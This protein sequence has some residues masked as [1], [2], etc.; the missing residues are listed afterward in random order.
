M[1]SNKRY[2]VTVLSSQMIIIP[3]VLTFMVVFVP[4][5]NRML[6]SLGFGNDAINFIAW[7]ISLIES[8]LVGGIVG[9]VYSWRAKHKPDSLRERYMPFFFSI[10]YALIWAILVM[11]FSKGDYNSGWW[12][13]YMIK[14][15][16]LI[17]Y[18]FTQIF[19][20]NHY[21][22]PVA[23]LMG[24]TGFVVG[25]LLQEYAT[26]TIILG[27]SFKGRNLEVGF[28][29][30]CVGVIIVSG[31]TAKNQ[32]RDG[33]I[34]LR[35]GK[36]TLGDDLTEIDLVRIAP[37]KE[38]NG[39][40]K[41][42]RPASLQFT[43]LDKMPLLDGATAAFP[44][45]G[46]FVEAVYKGLG[47]YN[48]A[49]KPNTEKDAELAFLASQQYPYNIVQCSKTDQAYDRLMRG[50]TDII[51]VAEPSKMHRET[52]KAQGDDFVL[53][54]IGSEAFVFFTNS[55][56]P[57]EN[58]TVKQIQDIYS[59]QITSWKEVGGQK[60]S[61]KPYQRPKNSGSQTVM[62]NKVM[63]DI[64]ML[65]PTEETYASGM[66]DI[67]KRV[68]NYKNA[69]NSLGYSFMYYSTQM[70]KNN[71]IKYL[72]IDGI[73]PTPKSVRDKTYPFTV[74]V[75]AVTLK[76]NMKENVNRFVQWVISEEGQSLVEKTGYIPIR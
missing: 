41:L 17:I 68:A 1:K 31:V 46:A 21:L 6:L 12:G 27:K 29:L 28:A 72:A 58:L 47:E 22:L 40:A 69:Q 64:A 11:V 14:N 36:S 73:K 35:Y 37:F 56:N 33:M 49:N 63:R 23:E 59:G 38:N 61:I 10:V 7:I 26:H 48:Q 45:Y 4:T 34:E 30:L 52:I 53:T 5:P 66:G 13:L 9:A 18:G 8:L 32:I 60:Q 39:L 55:K 24:Y 19:S 75:Y 42:D 62:Q 76:S 65:E 16:F 71:Q 25:V 74:P 3:L 70:V 2:I 50:E 51:F 44:V 15:P 67:I 20:G 57:V 54:P 43:E